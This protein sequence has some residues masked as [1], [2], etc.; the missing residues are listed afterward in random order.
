MVTVIVLDEAPQCFPRRGVFNY[1]PLSNGDCRLSGVGFNHGNRFSL[2]VNRFLW[3][4]SAAFTPDD[5][6]V[7]GLYGI[8][9]IYYACHYR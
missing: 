3:H 8:S 1:L 7:I 9:G 6:L 5:H 4:L 2:V